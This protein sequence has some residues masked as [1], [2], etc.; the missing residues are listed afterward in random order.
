MFT[1]TRR[2]VLAA[3]G[4]AT[5]VSKT[6]ARETGDLVLRAASVRRA[7]AGDAAADVDLELFEGRTP[8]PVM[9]AQRGRPATLELVNG[10]ARPLSFVVEGLRSPDALIGPP[11]PRAAPLAPGET[12]RIALDTR[13]AGT[14]LYR[15]LDD[16]GWAN[17]LCG[18]LIVDDPGP[19]LADHDIALLAEVRGPTGARTA[20]INGAR[21]LAIAARAGDRLRLRLANGAPFD[22]LGIVVEGPPVVLVALDGQPSEPFALANGTLL[23]GPGQRADLVIDVPPAI[24]RAPIRFALGPETIEGAIEIGDGEAGRAPRAPIGPLPDNP[25][26]KTMDFRR[27]HRLGLSVARAAFAGATG[28]TPGA[29]P[30]FRVRAGTVVMAGLANDTDA[31]ASV[32][33][34]GHAMRLLDGLDDGWKPFFL[35]ACLIAPGRTERVAFR[36]ESP[37]RYPMIARIMGDPTSTRVAWFEVT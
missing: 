31:V 16:A 9:R 1:P 5:L 24:R 23:L 35:G 26:A 30:L 13:D 28:A 33:V 14:F 6:H 27:A 17:G 34:H 12:R 19:P 20:T 4:A 7:I 29:S 22:M 25:I 3:A 18:L 37:G 36:T 32:T 10:L 15:A 11:H 21:T 8:G 2:L